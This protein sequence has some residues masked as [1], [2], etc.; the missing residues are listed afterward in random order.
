MKILEEFMEHLCGEFTNE[1]QI[2][3]EEKEGKVVHPIARHINGICNDK[4]KNL[5]KDFKGYFVIEE[6]YYT[7]GNFKN[8]LPHLFLFTVNSEDKVV[9]TSYDIPKEISKEDFRNN[10]KNII[11]EYTKLEVSKKFA[12]MVYEKIENGFKG[13]SISNFT[14]STRFELRE[15][16]TNEAM[17]VSEAFFNNDKMTFGFIQPIIY[18]IVT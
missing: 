12:P 9:L 18:K 3:Q 10:N 8:T 14:E 7:M 5:P 15:T 1:E 4:I 13:E 6:S 17:Y 16:I 11:L 2:R